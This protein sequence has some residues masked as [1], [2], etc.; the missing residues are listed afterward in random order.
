MIISKTR[1]LS[2][3]QQGM[4]NWVLN[5]GLVFETACAAFLIYFP[6]SFVVG[7]Y[8][9]APEWWIPALPFSL[10]IWVG[11]ETRRYF[12]R[13]A[14]RQE[15]WLGDFLTMETYY[16]LLVFVIIIYVHCPSDPEN[17]VHVL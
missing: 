5:F 17:I 2:I 14:L 13:L 1:V 7:F 4:N 16:W 12:I 15:T 11:D 6:Y 10:L 9:V 3:F 8:P